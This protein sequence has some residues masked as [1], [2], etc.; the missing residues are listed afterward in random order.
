[1]RDG[2][3]PRLQDFL[4]VDIK[5]V[6]VEVEINALTNVD[7]E[8]FKRACERASWCGWLCLNRS[9]SRCWLCDFN[10]GL[11]LNLFNRLRLGSTRADREYNRGCGCEFK[12][13]I[14]CYSD[15]PGC[16]EC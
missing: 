8:V 11:F 5:A 6:A 4:I 13:G 1:M 12:S 9:R 10:R 3:T 15:S 16:P 14:H 7:A 2:S